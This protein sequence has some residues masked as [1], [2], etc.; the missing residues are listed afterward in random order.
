MRKMK[1]KTDY[2]IKTEHD[3]DGKVMQWPRRLY[4]KS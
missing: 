2:R 3:F 4:L 1:H